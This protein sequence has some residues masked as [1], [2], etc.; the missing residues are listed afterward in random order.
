[1]FKCRALEANP[2][3]GGFEDFNT[4]TNLMELDLATNF[5]ATSWLEPI[6]GLP[7]LERLSILVADLEPGLGA[8]LFLWSRCLTYLHVRGA[9]FDGLLVHPSDTFVG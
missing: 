5:Q 6:M 3:V 7:G 2:G 1:M 9:G 4:L 8:Q